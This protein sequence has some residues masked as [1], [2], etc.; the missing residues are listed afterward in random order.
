MKHKIIFSG[1]SIDLNQTDADVMKD[2]QAAIDQ[3]FPQPNN[4]VK[5]ANC[6]ETDAN[7]FELVIKRQYDSGGGMSLGSG[8]IC[9]QDESLIT[10]LSIDTFQPFKPGC[11]L[12]APM[13]SWYDDMVYTPDTE[14][15]RLWKKMN[16]VMVQEKIKK[17]K[18]SPTGSS[19]LIKLKFA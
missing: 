4:F 17:I 9:D 16:E 8:F 14:F 5:V 1:K 6:K 3:F 13:I 19:I 2:M 15:V 7:T 12:V 11:A 18:I 10:G